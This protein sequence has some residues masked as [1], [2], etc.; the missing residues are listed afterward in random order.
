MLKECNHYRFYAEFPVMIPVD[1]VEKLQQELDEVVCKPI[2]NTIHITFAEIGNKETGGY[3]EIV[4]HIL[5]DIPLGGTEG[6]LGPIFSGHGLEPS[7]TVTQLDSGIIDVMPILIGVGIVGVA[8]YYLR[9][10]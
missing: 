4:I 10:R 6:L 5:R 8:I 3:I 2:D 1:I 9:K 7:F